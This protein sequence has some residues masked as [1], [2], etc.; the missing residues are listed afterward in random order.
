M[1]DSA[2]S[3]SE[4][5][6]AMTLDDLMRTGATKWDALDGTIGAFVA[7]MDFGVAPPISEAL[8]D[9]V[10]RG[11][12]GYMPQGLVRELSIATAAWLSARYD[13]AVAAS[14]VKAV[15]DVIRALQYAIEH[16]SNPGS[17]II[18]PTPAYKPFLLVP[19][20]LGRKVIEVPMH[21][22]A[23][24]RYALDLDA[25]QRAYDGD[26]H[27]LVLCNPHNP[28][29]QVFD[30]KELIAVSE[31][32]TRNQG[33]VFSDEIWAP[34]VFP[35][36]SHIPYASISPAAAGH[37]FTA[38]AASKAWNLPGL[39][40][41]QVVLTSDADRELWQVRGPL[42][43]HGASNLGAIATIAAY[44]A[45]ATWLAEVKDYL[46]QNR[47]VMATLVKEYLPGVRFSEPDGGYV[48]WLDFRN[49]HIAES[50]AAFFR[51]HAAVSLTEGSDCGQAGLGFGR[52][53]FAMPRPVMREA[54]RRMGSAFTHLR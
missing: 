5:V 2:R 20:M 23:T 40:C 44:R 37:A 36:N 32:V 7:E 47:Q 19:K 15:P 28:S 42:A 3:F 9:A 8:H 30:R 6:D 25:L 16:V 49:T 27:L 51:R 46:L 45:G 14:N 17:S 29:G 24:G 13:W 52:F 10:D 21:L 12:F 50:P 26:G 35:G 48:G 53:T 31:L 1:N 18:V 22:A 38:I 41:A 39:K 54:F 33:R 43:S 11:N 4:R 34:L